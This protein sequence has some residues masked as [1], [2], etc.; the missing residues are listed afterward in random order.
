M[1]GAQGTGKMKGKNPPW[2]SVWLGVWGL[3]C[4]GPFDPGVAK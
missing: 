3:G 2:E 4:P 1:A